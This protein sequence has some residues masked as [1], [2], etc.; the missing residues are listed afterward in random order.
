MNRYRPLSEYGRAIYGDAPVDLDLSVMDEKD[1][2]DGGHL[3]I[4]PRT[5]KVLSDN[6]SG[7]PQGGEYMGALRKEIED[8]LI[9]GGHIKRLDEPPAAIQDEVPPGTGVDGGDTTFK[10]TTAEGAKAKK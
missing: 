3:E 5:Y 10:D 9:Q 7:A 4:V 8:A 6:F 1:A 2:L